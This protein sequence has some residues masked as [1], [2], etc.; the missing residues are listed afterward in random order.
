M[1]QLPIKESY[2]AG[3]NLY[4]GVYPYCVDPREGLERVQQFIDFGMETFID[5]THPSDNLFSYKQHLPKAIEHRPFPV[6]DYTVPKLPLLKKIHE[7]IDPEKK[8]YIHCIGG[9]DRTSIV[10]AT[11]F[12]YEDPEITLEMIK[13]KFLAKFLHYPVR[14]R[15]NYRASL[16][17][18]HW[19]VVTKYQQYL[20]CKT[21]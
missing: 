11:Y 18:S 19:D 4:A 14:K 21:K 1:A 7:I 5:L 3:G 8:T 16:L 12:A 10:V 13:Q 17:F 15:H 2:K 20:T 6:I 9:Y